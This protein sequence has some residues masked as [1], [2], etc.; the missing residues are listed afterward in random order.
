METD[1]IVELATTVLLEMNDKIGDRWGRTKL[2]VV[3]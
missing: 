2:A 3:I 1:D